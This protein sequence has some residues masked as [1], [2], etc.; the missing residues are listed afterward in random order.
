MEHFFFGVCMYVCMYMSQ[1]L[2][3]QVC[4]VY[5]VNSMCSVFV[6][7]NGIEEIGG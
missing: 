4:D 7:L 1:P 2:L 3:I 5:L 6:M